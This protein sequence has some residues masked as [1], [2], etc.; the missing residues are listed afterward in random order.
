MKLNKLKKIKNLEERVE[1]NKFPSGKKVL[2]HFLHRH[3]SL[4]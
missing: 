1:G 2:G 3:I 4:M